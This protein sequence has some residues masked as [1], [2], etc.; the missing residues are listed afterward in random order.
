MTKVKL[1]F[2]EHLTIAEDLRKVR[3]VLLITQSKIESAYPRKTK[4]NLS[5]LK[6]LMEIDNLRSG[7]DDY[8]YQLPDVIGIEQISSPYYMGDR[9]FLKEWNAANRGVGNE[10][11]LQ[12]KKENKKRC[13]G[14]CSS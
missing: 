8:F 9:A 4:A 13:N 10:S 3:A 14:K 7:L 2:D 1:D 5:L 11:K 6:I 12:I